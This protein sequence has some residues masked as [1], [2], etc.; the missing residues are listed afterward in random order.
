MPLWFAIRVDILSI[1]TL[2]TV[3]TI[4]VL[5]RFSGNSIMLSLLL[6]YVLNFQSCLMMVV[7]LLMDIEARFVNVERL[8]S[9]LKVPQENVEGD[10]SLE[11]FKERN[12]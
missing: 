10:L 9:L 1:F 12:P 7:R 3:S 4:C 6:T 8:L 11:E 5:A 2:A